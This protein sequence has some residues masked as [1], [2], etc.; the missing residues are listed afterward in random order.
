MGQ[1]TTKTHTEYFIDHRAEGLFTRSINVTVFMTGTFHLFG[2]M[3]K[4]CQRTTFDPFLNGTKYG[5]IDGTCKQSLR[6]GW[7]WSGSGER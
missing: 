3:C 1:D 6:S 7:G 4:W 5:E 2:V